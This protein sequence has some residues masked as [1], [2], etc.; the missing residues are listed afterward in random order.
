MDLNQNHMDNNRYVSPSKDSNV[1]IINKEEYQLI[2]FNKYLVL[3]SYDPISIAYKVRRDVCQMSGWIK[4][5]RNSKRNIHFP[6]EC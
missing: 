5:R 4:K 1:I 6:S 2:D 3:Q